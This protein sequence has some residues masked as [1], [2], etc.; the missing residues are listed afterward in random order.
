MYAL[1]VIF[2]FFFSNMCL[3]N[4]SIALGVQISQKYKG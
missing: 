3:P 2:F 1:F 4:E